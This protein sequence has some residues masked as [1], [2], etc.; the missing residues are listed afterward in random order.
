MTV[1][2]RC[3]CSSHSRFPPTK[4]FMV[5]SK[6]SRRR[7]SPSYAPQARLPAERV[8]LESVGQLRL[9]LNDR[10]AWS[11]SPDAARDRRSP[12]GIGACDV[13]DDG[14]ALEYPKTIKALPVSRCLADS[15][16]PPQS[17]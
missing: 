14:L 7:L 4:F 9:F 16:H 13:D 1:A 15:G 6:P 3:I 12:R 8:L 5:S 2:H 17:G 11:Y 10:A